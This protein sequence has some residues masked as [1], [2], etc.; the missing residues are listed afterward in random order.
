MVS[1]L[2]AIIVKKVANNGSIMV[3]ILAAIVVKRSPIMAP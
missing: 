1:I 3:S 2:A